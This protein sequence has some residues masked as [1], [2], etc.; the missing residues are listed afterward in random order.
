VET[1][2]RQYEI[3]NSHGFQMATENRRHKR[4]KKEKQSD[5]YTGF[6][7]NRLNRPDVVHGTPWSWMEDSYRVSF[8][9][10][11]W[12]IHTHV[13]GLCIVTYEGEVDGT[14]LLVTTGQSVQPTTPL[15]HNIPCGVHG[16]VLEI[17]PKWHEMRNDALQTGFLCII[18]PSGR[19][20]PE[21]K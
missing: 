17:N 16:K 21:F 2:S 10:A 14:K 12:Q 8:Q 5:A 7:Y 4:R 6:V 9:D 13:N 19:F 3:Q 11:D 18:Q 20:P 15:L 1:D